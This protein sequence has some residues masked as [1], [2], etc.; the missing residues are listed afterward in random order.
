[1]SDDPDRGRAIFNARFEELERHLIACGL[2]GQ[3]RA[4]ALGLVIATHKA[5]DAVE[6]INAQD[7]AERAADL[8]EMVERIHEAGSAAADDEGG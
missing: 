1:M 4:H 5:W 7:A 2:S 3:Q 6:T 8:A